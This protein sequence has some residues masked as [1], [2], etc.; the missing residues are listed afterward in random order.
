MEPK[1]TLEEHSGGVWTLFYRMVFTVHQS[2]YQVQAEQPLL[3]RVGEFDGD[4][5]GARGGNKGLFIR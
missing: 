3:F 5:M 4:I 2:C 1:V